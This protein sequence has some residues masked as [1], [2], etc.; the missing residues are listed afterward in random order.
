MGETS[1]FAPVRNRPAQFHWDFSPAN[2][3]EAEEEQSAHNMVSLFRQ[4]KRL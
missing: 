1:V 2:V 4:W 3:K